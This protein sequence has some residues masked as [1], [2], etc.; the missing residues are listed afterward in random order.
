MIPSLFLDSV[1]I[2]ENCGLRYRKILKFQFPLSPDSS[3][4]F[5]LVILRNLPTYRSSFLQKII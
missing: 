2:F 1:E 4:Q 5:F 3:G